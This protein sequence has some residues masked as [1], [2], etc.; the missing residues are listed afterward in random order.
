MPRRP[1]PLQTTRML[2]AGTLLWLIYA[3]IWIWYPQ[4]SSKHAV[5]FVTALYNVCLFGGL[6]FL[7]VGMFLRASAWAQAWRDGTD[8]PYDF[9]AD[10]IVSERTDFPAEDD[11]DF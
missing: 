3:V 10:V 1:E 5:G 7:A 2:G 8:A 6:L 9:P 4:P 11:P